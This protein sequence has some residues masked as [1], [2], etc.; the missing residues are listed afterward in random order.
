MNV[1]RSHPQ[2]SVVQPDVTQCIKFSQLYH[3]CCYRMWSSKNTTYWNHMIMWE[4]PFSLKARS[5]CWM[6]QTKLNIFKCYS[7]KTVVR[8]EWRGKAINEETENFMLNW[9][10]IITKKCWVKYKNMTMIKTACYRNRNTFEKSKK[11]R[12]VKF[13]VGNNLLVHGNICCVT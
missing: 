3:L 7:W 13:W 5:F 8:K 10:F 11:E 12:I 1:S 9:N 2:H 6:K 4:I